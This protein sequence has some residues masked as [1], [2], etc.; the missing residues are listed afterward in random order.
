MTKRTNTRGPQPLNFYSW[1]RR[2]IVREEASFFRLEL[3]TG[4]ERVVRILNKSVRPN[5]RTIEQ[6]K[7][8]RV[9]A[10]NEAGDV[11]GVWDF[12]ENAEPE[13]PEAPGYEKSPDDTEPQRDLKVVAHL[14]AGAYKDSIGALK[15]VI[16]I[17]G[18]TFA[19]ERKG[20]GATIQ[21]V[22]RLVGKVGKLRVRVAAPPEAPADDDD[23]TWVEDFIGS[24]VKA[25]MRQ[26]MMNGGTADEP[27]TDPPEPE[28][29][30]DAG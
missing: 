2:R 21:G 3:A 23:D 28:R 9:E 16:R 4:K 22:E 13:E 1:A 17:Q 24:I 19:N 25:K 14:I 11:L 30:T 27:E 26:Q 6:L 29:G 12:P 15:D 18:E 7:P 5:V 8:V 20:M 10:C